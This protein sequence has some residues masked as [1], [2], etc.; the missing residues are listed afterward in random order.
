MRFYY[1]PRLLVI[2]ELA[3]ARHNPDPH[4]RED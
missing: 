3:Y 2:D 4:L 1:A